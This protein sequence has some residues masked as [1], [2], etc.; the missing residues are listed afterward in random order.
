MQVQLKGSAYYPVLSA[1]SM[2]LHLWIFKLHFHHSSSDSKN[3]IFSLVGLNSII[4]R[5]LPLSGK[6]MFD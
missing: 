5:D 2:Q 3:D 4:P 1:P 6:I